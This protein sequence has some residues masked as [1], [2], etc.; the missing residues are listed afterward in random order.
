[1][2]PA[3]KAFLGSRFNKKVA[4]EAQKARSVELCAAMRMA[5][6]WLGQHKRDEASNLFTPVYGRFTEGF[7][8]AAGSTHPKD[9]LR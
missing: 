3:E 2:A 4:A 8:L 6:L 7:N 5:G 9:H 1:V